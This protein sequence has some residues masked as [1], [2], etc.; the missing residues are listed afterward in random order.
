MIVNIRKFLFY[1]LSLD[2]QEFI[3]R[4]QEAGFI[5]FISDRDRSESS[6]SLKVEHIKQAIKVLK[7]LPVL[8]DYDHY[9]SQ[10]ELLDKAYTI[11]Q[12]QERLDR[13][14]EELRITQAE[15]VKLKP[16][17]FF[18]IEDLRSIYDQT[19]Y[20]FQFF[21]RSSVTLGQID[22]EL[23]YLGTE[24]DLDY[25]VAI[26]QN[27]LN[28]SDFIEIKIE[29]S[30]N[31]SLERQDKLEHY[32][33]QTEK[34]LKGMASVLNALEMTLGQYSDLE[35]LEQ[36]YK[37]ASFPLESQLFTL[38]AF[39]PENRE[40]HLPK[41]LKGL[42]IQVDVIKP[43]PDELLPTCFYNKGL[44]KSGEDLV[45]IYD[46]PSS[47]DK[48]PSKWV[49]WAFALFFAMIVADA[50]YGLIYLSI[51]LL[52]QKRL[53][54][55]TAFIK[56]SLNLL[57]TLGCSCVIWG[58]LTG[59]WFGIPL[60]QTNVLQKFTMIQ[61]LIEKKADYHIKEQD[62]TIKEVQGKF[63]LNSVSTRSDLLEFKDSEGKT[64]I[65]D[66]F[67][68]NILLELSLF[69]G[70]VHIIFSLLRYLPTRLPNVGWVLFA[71]GG[72]LYFPSYLHA[73]SLM[74]IL[75][76]VSLKLGAAIG[77][78]LIF[79]GIGMSLLI[80]VIQKGLKGLGEIANLVQVFADILSYLR[81][82]ALALASSILAG[83]FNGMG[84]SLGL[85]F[86]GIIILAG[87]IV[88][89]TLG[90]MGGII[91]GLRLNFIEWYH[92]SFEGGGKLFKPL[93]RFTFKN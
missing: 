21:C 46:I 24:Y 77:Q 58:A 23:I 9:L 20:K 80:A 93:K 81:L 59:A 36:T 88:N 44:A 22:P 69:V 63:H 68:K 73:P 32:I 49:F 50:G 55:K 38:M 71:L 76:L 14:N 37:M 41:L 17:G 51:A 1:G 42:A 16:L 5:E 4:A 19:G 13:L 2:L 86:G 26:C 90:A 35:A 61:C 89:F 27:S 67:Y 83:T 52:A 66:V 12:L 7:K 72:Y 62:S 10:D 3:A 11:N 8:P 28:F 75:D 34:E 54:T 56:R 39:V 60:S 92:Y 40:S 57:K 64:P 43:D 85:V 84:A 79:I 53:K 82:Y 45:K 29:Q 30:L 47:R 78:Q 48:D 74:Q 70:I 15:V 31:E 18:D 65:Y 25:Y 6:V 33:K 87:H 91:H